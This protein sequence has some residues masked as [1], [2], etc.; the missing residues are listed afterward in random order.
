MITL[1]GLQTNTVIPEIGAEVKI[2]SKKN[3]IMAKSDREKRRAERRERRSDRRSD[4]RDFKIEKK[5]V[6][7]D[8]RTDR[9]DIR[10][11][12]R[13]DKA[14]AKYDAH[15]VAYSHGIDPKASTN[16]MIA[17][18]GASAAHVVGG[19]TGAP[20][21]WPSPGG[22]VGINGGNTPVFVAEDDITVGAS[23]NNNMMFWL[24]GLVAGLFLIFKN[25]K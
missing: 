2:D 21:G 7:Q 10:T 9:T 6:K 24:V 11:S 19:L 5:T 22:N 14:E 25:K 15:E 17:S 1:G 8:A 3:E 13:V 20:G 18:L 16:N 23:V 4:R 12:G